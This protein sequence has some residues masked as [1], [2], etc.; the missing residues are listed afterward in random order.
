MAS[1]TSSSSD[2][3]TDLSP[4]I[5]VYKDGK[6]ERLLG[7]PFVPA[8]PED[9][10]TGVSSKDVNISP[11][12]SARLY[13]PKAKSIESSEKLPILI[14]YHGGGFCLD[15]A[16]YFLCHRY[17]NLLVSQAKAVAIS[18]NYR[19]AP[20]FPL[21]AAYEDSWTAITWVASHSVSDID[22]GGV[23]EPWLLNHGNFDKIYLVGDSSGGNIVH[24]LAIKA[25][26]ESLP[27]D[28]KIA[29]GIISHPF[30]WGSKFQSSRKAETTPS[31]QQRY[32]HS[33]YYYRLW[34]FAY[35]SAPGGIDNPMV[36]P[37]PLLLAGEDDHDDAAP[38]PPPS[39]SGIGC[40]KLMVCTSE[41]DDIRETSVLY[42]DAVKKS[43][44]KGEVEFV[45][46]EGE[47]HC[48]QIFKPETENAKNFINRMAS[49]INS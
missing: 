41:K 47:G 46:I 9:P 24:N 5:R 29:G 20:E 4:F 28:V 17:V 37:F 18:V 38:P 45:D 11:Q 35:P 43:G 23:K 21:P 49:F 33:S 26:G 27:G 7:S 42:V 39:L 44:W 15:S 34:M 30:F 48:F 12:V 2:I 16:F 10:T 32:Y 3:V 25:G 1:S 22:I 13:L 19:L 6:V 40:R 8:G 36:N 14:Y 31:D